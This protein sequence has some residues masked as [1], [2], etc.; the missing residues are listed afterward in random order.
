MKRVLVLLMAVTLT[1]SVNAGLLHRYDFETDA[2]DSVGTAHGTVYGS[3]SVTGGGL[4]S[5]GGWINGQLNAGVPNNGALLDASAVSGITGA[6]TI[7]CW[8]TAGWG[9]GYTTAFSFSDGTTANYVLGTPARGNAPYASSVAVI[10]GG[11]GLGEQQAAG[12]WF[13]TGDLLH[14]LVTYDGT[15]LTYY[16]NTSTDFDGFNTANG[17]SAS[18]VVPGLDLSTL[19]QIGINGGA[20]WPDN[21]M[22][23]SVWDFRIYD[24]AFS[25]NQVAALYAL[26]ADATNADI[27]AVIP[28]PATLMLLGLGSVALLRKRK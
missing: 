23:G 1:L 7:E 22:N 11:T 19:T 16:Q 12:R 15:T 20:P 14:M 26:G 17:L 3:A 25:A 24:N 2:S 27:I 18:I 28:E 4:Y 10:G 6:F 21:S 9:G 5:G 8:M 13:D